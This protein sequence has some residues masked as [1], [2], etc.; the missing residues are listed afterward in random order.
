MDDTQAVDRH[1][2]MCARTKANGRPSYHQPQSDIL[3]ECL[4]VRE[5]ALL[6]LRRA[7]VRRDAATSGMSTPAECKVQE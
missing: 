5:E 1:H 6:G 2:Q 3:I 4:F 7:Y